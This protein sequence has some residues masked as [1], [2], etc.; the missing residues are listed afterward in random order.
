MSTIDR[1]R[2]GR[3]VGEREIDWERPLDNEF[4]VAEEVT[5]AATNARRPAGVLVNGLALGILEDNESKRVALYRLAGGV[6][7]RQPR[8]EL[9]EAGYSDAETRFRY[10]PVRVQRPRIVMPLAAPGSVRSKTSSKVRSSIRSMVRV[11]R[12]PGAFS[13]ASRTKTRRSRSVD[14][15][16]R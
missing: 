15:S 8:H 11:A 12:V 9:R 7:A 16:S 1:S 6:P 10:C 13:E 4:A 3:T 2:A 5:V 14:A